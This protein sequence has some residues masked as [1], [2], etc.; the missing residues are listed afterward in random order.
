MGELWN[1]LEEN[2]VPQVPLCDWNWL[3]WNKHRGVSNVN[4]VE[5]PWDNCHSVAAIEVSNDNIFE[6][7]I[8]NLKDLADVENSQGLE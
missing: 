5:E 8:E 1:N 2:S 3:M 4:K 7:R 6:V